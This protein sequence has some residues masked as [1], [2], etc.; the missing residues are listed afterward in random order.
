MRG[1]ATHPVPARLQFIRM[2]RGFLP[3]DAEVRETTY[4]AGS[5]HTEATSFV[6]LL[7]YTQC[8]GSAAEIQ[9]VCAESAAHTACK[10][11]AK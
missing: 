11:G 4:L 8:Q 6:P 1:Q 10:L 9:P 2:D 7:R 5:S 3:N